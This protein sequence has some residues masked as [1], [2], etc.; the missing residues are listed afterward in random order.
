MPTLCQQHILYRSFIYA[1]TVGDP[2]I[3]RVRDS[4]KRLNPTKCQARI[5][6]SDVIIGGLFYV[7]W[8]HA[9]RG[10]CLS[11]WYRQGLWEGGSV[12]KGLVNLWRAPSP[13]IAIYVLFSIFYYLWYFEKSQS[14]FGDPKQSCSTMQNLHGAL[15]IGGAVH[16]Y[17]VFSN[18]IGYDQVYKQ[19]LTNVHVTWKWQDV[20]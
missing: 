14:V 18:T 17:I 19:M 11:C 5:C 7:E 10:S 1:Y 3:K 6:V 12:K 16:C 20:V 8:L 2:V 4:I 13:L 9:V 15:S